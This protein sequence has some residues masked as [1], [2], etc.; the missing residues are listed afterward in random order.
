MSD[1]KIPPG[2]LAAET[3][4]RFGHLTRHFP[5]AVSSEA[6]ALAWANTESGPDGAVVVVDHE[7]GARGFLGRVW[8]TPPAD[9]LA[10]S[11]VLRPALAAEQGDIT[12]LVAGLVAAEGAEA[13]SGVKLATWWPD[14]VIDASTGEEVAA[15]RS[16]IQ[17]GPG[18]VK[19]VVLTLRLDLARLGLGPE[20]RDELL[21]AVVHAVDTVSERLGEGT[22]VIAA[23]YEERCPLMGKRMKLKLR[24][25]GETRGTAR[26][27]DKLARL[28]LESTTGMVERI[29]IDQLLS[30]VVV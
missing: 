25:K 4:E 12:W 2:G 15:V 6:M 18:K 7:V 28:Q 11:V 19:S 10:C 22:E 3:V 16:E 9:T 17:L 30:L 1:Y 20:R 29:G 23:A 27:I 26:H 14:S 21:E 8:S 24:P 13:A 5:V